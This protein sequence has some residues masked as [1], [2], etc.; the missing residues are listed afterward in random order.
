MMEILLGL[1]DDMRDIRGRLTALEEQRDLSLP[2][3]FCAEVV[4]TWGNVHIPQ[5]RN[6][7]RMEVGKVFKEYALPSDLS[8][9]REY[10]ADTQRNLQLLDKTLAALKPNPAD[11]IELMGVIHRVVV[12]L[13]ATLHL[14]KYGRSSA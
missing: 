2:A 6:L 8:S 9:T 1:R 13:S 5:V 3:G 11:N 4:A 10:E 14:G 7:I 12:A